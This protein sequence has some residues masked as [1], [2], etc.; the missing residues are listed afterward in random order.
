MVLTLLVSSSVLTTDG[1]AVAVISILDEENCNWAIRDPFLSRV[2]F[3]IVMVLILNH[4]GLLKT[5]GVLRFHGII[6]QISFS[7]YRH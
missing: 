1:A 6:R 2:F 7:A 4:F 3:T 5:K